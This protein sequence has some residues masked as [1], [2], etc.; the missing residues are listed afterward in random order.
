MWSVSRAHALALPSKPLNQIS[1]SD[2]DSASSLSFVKQKLH[3][4]GVDVKFTQAQVQYVG[5]LGGRASDLESVRGFFL[6]APALLLTRRR[7][8]RPQDA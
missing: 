4:G 5:R 2:A 3:D 8:A 1:L 6:T 7:A